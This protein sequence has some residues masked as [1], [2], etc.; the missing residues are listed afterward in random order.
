MSDEVGDEWFEK[1]AVN[2]HSFLIGS[3]GKKLLQ[4]WKHTVYLEVMDADIKTEWDD[5]RRSGMAS[6]IIGTENLSII[7]EF[8]AEEDEELAE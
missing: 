4:R 8:P 1:D 6:L 7:D 3:T 5:G 2:L